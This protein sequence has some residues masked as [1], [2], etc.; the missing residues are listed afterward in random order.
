M[1]R[2]K[3][4]HRPTIFFTV[5]HYKG[6]AQQFLSLCGILPSPLARLMNESKCTLPVAESA[7]SISFNFEPS[8]SFS[9][10]LNFRL[11]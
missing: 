11:I 6:I 5:Q 7:Y 10:T 4:Y 8:S 9:N 3:T 1:F 2:S